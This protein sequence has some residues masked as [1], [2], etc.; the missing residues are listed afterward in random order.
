MKKILLATS[1]AWLAAAGPSHAVAPYDALAVGPHC[2]SVVADDQ[3]IQACTTLIEDPAAEPAILFGAYSSRAKGFL[4]MGKPDLAVADATRAIALRP[5]SESNYAVRATAYKNLKKSAESRADAA[6]TI[7]LATKAI[8]AAPRADAYGDRAMAH[9]LSGNDAEALTDV[10]QALALAPDEARLIG[11]RGQIQQ[12]L[13]KRDAAIADFVAALKIDPILDSA[14]SGL[15]ELGA[16][17]SMDQTWSLCAGGSHGSARIDTCTAVLARKG[18]QP[19]WVAN[20]RENRSIGY[21][22]VGDFLSATTDLT[23]AIN[24]TPWDGQP[25]AFRSA[26]YRA[27][28]QN[29]QALAD[30]ERA[31]M[32]M[33]SSGQ[34]YGE[35]GW[36]RNRKGDLEGALQDATHAIDL[37]PKIADNF[38][39]RAAVQKRRNK[40]DDAISDY[41]SAIRLS[42][43]F[44][45]AYRSR[46]EVYLQKKQPDQAID[47]ASTALRLQP[48]NWNALFVRARSHDLKNETDAAIA[49]YT[50]LIAHRSVAV[51]YSN[52]GWAL[53]LKGKN[54]D[55]LQDAAKAVTL[56]PKSTDF[57]VN[58]SQIYLSLG[59]IAEAEADAN[60]IV[61]LAPD[62]A[63]SYANRGA[64]LIAAKKYDQAITDLDKAV[65]IDPSP[66]AYYYRAQA[67]NLKGDA[68]GA[69]PDVAKALELTPRDPELLALRAVLH[70]NTGDS[71]AAIADYTAAIAIFP[72]ARFYNN[73]AWALHIKGDDA[74][75]LPDA[76]KALERNPKQPSFLETRAEIYEKLNRRDEAIADYRAALAGDPAMKSAQDGLARMGVT[77]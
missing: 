21:S 14:M 15:K 3:Q 17:N 41:T 16:E 35:R 58:R 55:A 66:T 6:Q 36:V 45:E 2:L 7:A 29:D 44:S 59:K 56:D 67:R 32:L 53:H 11:I 37:D 13:G 31:V 69:M 48:E 33:P 4:A 26:A 64:V 61:T 50:Q 19:D 22:E 34:A 52:R 73:R 65:S 24:A 57:L 75:G 49:D 63:L 38:M 60:G 30:A 62:K 42:P 43:D 51:D 46:A 10:N 77:P 76:M 23:V 27:Q 40:P 71:D 28:N 39:L 18:L 54:E 72:A 25:Y 8:A 74:K 1:V 47:D 68:A 20:A 9:H 12:S 70:Q 5:D